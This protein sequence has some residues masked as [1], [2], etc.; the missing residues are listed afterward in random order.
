MRTMI[1]ATAALTLV[2]SAAPALAQS[3]S[4]SDAN[5]LLGKLGT[6]AANLCSDSDKGKEREPIEHFN[7]CQTALSELA[8][9]RNKDS[10]ASPGKLQVYDFMESALLMGNTFAMLR[11]DQ[12]P[13]VR[14]CSNIELQWVVANR[15]DSALVGPTMDEALNTTK[16]MIQP[17][18]K[19]CREQF[20]ELAGKIP[21]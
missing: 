16:T 5:T 2:F 19:M 15:K 3:I 6:P 9:T 20:P 17:L 4:D 7:A 11:I 13:T 12:R 18:V 14:V 8:N 10:K 21:A 1:A